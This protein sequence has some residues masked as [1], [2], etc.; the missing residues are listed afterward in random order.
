ML[1]RNRLGEDRFTDPRHVFDQNVPLTEQGDEHQL[2]F[3]ALADDDRST[4]VMMLSATDLR[5]TSILKAPQY[6]N[7]G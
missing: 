7:L 5:S 1:L 4:F 2:D 3:A 6:I